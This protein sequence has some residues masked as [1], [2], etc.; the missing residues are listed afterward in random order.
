M[1]YYCK[2]CFSKN[3]VCDALVTLNNDVDE[4][5][6]YSISEVEELDSVYCNQ[7]ESSSISTIKATKFSLQ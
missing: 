3:I 4:K 1:S 2:N 7:C 5:G 6:Y